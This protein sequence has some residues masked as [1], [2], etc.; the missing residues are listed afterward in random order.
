MSE[1]LIT[2]ILKSSRRSKVDRRNFLRTVRTE[3]YGPGT[4]GVMQAGR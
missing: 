4:G 3:Q 1:L 2:G